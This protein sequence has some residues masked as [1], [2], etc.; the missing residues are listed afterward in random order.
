MIG[1]LAGGCLAIWGAVSIVFVITRLLGDPA[2]LLLPIGATPAQL[3][4]LTA[5]LGLDQPL[6][7]QYLRYLG[8]LFHGDLGQSFSMGRPA[9]QVVLQRLP[10]TALLAATALLLGSLGG[11][12]LAVLG[13]VARDGWGRWLVRP[14][15][16]LAQATPTFWLG[17]LLVMIFAVRLGW[18]PSGGYGSPAHLVLPAAT[19]GCYIAASVARYLDSSLMEALRGEHVRTA[20]AM[21]LGA[22]TVF[23]WHVLRNALVPVVTYLGMI[24]GELL[25]GAVVVESVF[26]W[27]GSGRLLV[28]AIM[29]KDFPVIQASVLVAAVLFVLMSLLTDGLYRWL[30][31]RAAVRGAHD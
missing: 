5:A 6:G 16:A 20:Q 2:A 4:A 13:V 8:Q 27:P 12:L 28:Q 31:P 21:G 23:T 10:A 15:V 26:S 18:L 14:L 9:L 22:A 3:Q 25:G 11:L 7:T 30:D 1:R 29:S 19:L 17:I 24:A